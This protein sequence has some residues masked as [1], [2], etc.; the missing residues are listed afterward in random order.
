MSIRIEEVAPGLDSGTRRF[1]Q[2]TDEYFNLV[3][4][5]G[6]LLLDGKQYNGDRE[7]NKESVEKVLRN[8]IDNIQS[9]IDKSKKKETLSELSSV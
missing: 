3:N 8:A 6:C 5:Q 4:P 9:R 1:H 2:A 7:K